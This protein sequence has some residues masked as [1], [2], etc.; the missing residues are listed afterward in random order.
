LVISQ[1]DLRK[2]NPKEKRPIGFFVIILL[3]D[4][5]LITILLFCLFFGFKHGYGMIERSDFILTEI[6]RC[7]N[8]KDQWKFILF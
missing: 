4:I 8:T 2:E 5:S 3:K 1:F 7:Y 6:K